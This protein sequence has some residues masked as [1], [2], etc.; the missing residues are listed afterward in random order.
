[1]SAPA[2][3]E[4]ALAAAD[5]SEAAEVAKLEAL[6]QKVEEAAEQLKLKLREEAAEASGASRPPSPNRCEDY[7]G[8]EVG[9]GPHSLLS[10]HPT[11]ILGRREGRK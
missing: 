3:A 8:T 10:P 4:P 1:M 9:M 6:E 7:C 5:A 2:A 11:Y